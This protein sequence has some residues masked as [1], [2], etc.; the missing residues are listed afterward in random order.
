MYRD[1]GLS[2][3]D[4]A[5]AGLSFVFP[6]FEDDVVTD[7][8]T[9][10]TTT[11]ESGLSPFDPLPPFPVFW[12]NPNPPP[13]IDWDAVPD[14]VSIGSTATT[15]LTDEEMGFAVGLVTAIGSHHSIMA[16]SPYWDAAEDDDSSTIS[17]L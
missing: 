3:S 13:P 1:Q 10:N 9:T 2:A 12:V 6:A 15:F 16:A 7:D 8:W 11:V 4:G 5:G 14:L 17:A